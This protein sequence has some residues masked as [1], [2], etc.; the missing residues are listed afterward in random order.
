MTGAGCP[1]WETHSSCLWLD[2]L[3]FTLSLPFGLFWPSLFQEGGRLGAQGPAVLLGAVGSLGPASRC[4]PPQRPHAWNG[5][6]ARA[7]S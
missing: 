4:T 2:L 3:R 1:V 7:T 6:P 5:A